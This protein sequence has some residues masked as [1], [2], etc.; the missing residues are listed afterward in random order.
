MTEL[1]VNTGEL[2]NGGNG[3]VSGAQ[4]IPEPLQP[5]VTSGTDALSLALAA[6]TNE[7]ELPLIEGMPKTKAEALA[8][9]ENII[10]A[11]GLYEQTD[12]QIA[13]QIRKALAELDG[14]GAGGGA[15]AAGGASG[16]AAGS[17]G[18]GAAGSAAGGAAGA[19][20]GGAADQMGQM[21]QMMGMPMQL[22]QQAA[23]I[24]MQLAGMAMQIP[25]GIMQG[26]QSGMQQVGQMTGQFGE[27][28]SAEKDEKAKLEDELRD[29]QEQPSEETQPDGAA[30][31]ETVGERAPEYVPRH[32]APETPQAGPAPETPPPAPK[33]AP[34]RP[35][36]SS[37]VL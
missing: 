37:I 36:D 4:A 19:A 6:R 14:A 2:A 20:G 23:Q 18:G 11:A 12:Q 35:A 30:P 3:L 9:A 31:D 10:R 8:T 22:A 24:P 15:G 33:P 25:Q 32:A 26:V 1:R 29:K 7:V 27:M 21:G 16:A 13:D 17:A 28:G 5:L 34:T